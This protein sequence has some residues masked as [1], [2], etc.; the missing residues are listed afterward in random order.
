MSR[1]HSAL[2][3]AGI[4]QGCLGA[5]PSIAHYD[6]VG[7]RPGCTP[8]PVAGAPVI[9]IQRLTASAAYDGTGIALRTSDVRLDDYRYHRW[10][11][12]VQ[13]Q[14]TELL[15]ESWRER[16]QFARVDI[17]ELASDASFIVSGRVLTFEE[18]AT[19]KAVRRAR[20]VLM[21][22]GRTTG[23]RVLYHQRLESEHPLTGSS[24][25]S[26]V[27]ALRAAVTDIA[28]ETAPDIA[29]AARRGETGGSS[30]A[31]TKRRS[32]PGPRGESSDS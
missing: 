7:R 18:L 24:V 28:L 26:L 1:L 21:L 9:T 25:D 29:A 14:V 31:G 10:T 19:S 5:P 12:A 17:D 16:G 30:P 3:A 27:E 15:A 6:L 23:G 32:C 8:A 11:A 4:L 20:V 13:D 22:T 2:L